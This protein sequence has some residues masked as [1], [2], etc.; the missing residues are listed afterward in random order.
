MEARLADLVALAASRGATY[1]DARSVEREHE[2]VNV[3][4]GAVESVMRT[5][6]RGVG[7]RVVHRG[8]WHRAHAASPPMRRSQSSVSA[9][10]LC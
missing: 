5:S 7:F 2:A 4:D 1:A 10:A 9:S 8:A 3:K 6:D